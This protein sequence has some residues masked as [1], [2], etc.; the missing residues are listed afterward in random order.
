MS[1]TCGNVLD[2]RS[3]AFTAMPRIVSSGAPTHG[4]DAAALQIGP[5][6]RERRGEGGRLWGKRG[7]WPPNAVARRSWS[8]VNTDR[9]DGMTSRGHAFVSAGESS[10]LVVG[11]GGYAA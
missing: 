10:L 9:S 3:S 7:Q 4:S 2:V 1:A 8:S 5:P 11:A 6:V